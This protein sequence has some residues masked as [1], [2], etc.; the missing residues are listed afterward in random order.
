MSINEENLRRKIPVCPICGG[1]YQ[2]KKPLFQWTHIEC[3]NCKAQFYSWDLTSESGIIED[4]TLIKMPKL[5]IIKEKYYKFE[6]LLNISKD[7]EYWKTID[8]DQAFV[9]SSQINDIINKI[10]SI[11]FLN[12]PI[13]FYLENNEE[14][15]DITDVFYI[16]NKI[17][18]ESAS[19]GLYGHGLMGSVS[20]GSFSEKPDKG[21]FCTCYL[22]NR[23]LVFFE[24]KTK[25]AFLG[26]VSQT[27]ELFSIIYLDNIE[28]INKHDFFKAKYIDLSIKNETKGIIKISYYCDIHKNDVDRDEY[29]KM[30][31]NTRELYIK[32]KNVINDKNIPIDVLNM[33]LAK[34]EISIEEYEK[35][36]KVLS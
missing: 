15:V 4:L 33:R 8:I 28:S 21:R 9:K 20:S 13:P 27:K 26:S 31:T 17:V 35:L 32:N 14:L 30:L 25:I 18:M 24:H 29:I 19:F 2:W 36:K 23:R 22:T 6:P 10:D 12:I 16:G 7:I 1:T 34:G 5:E 11:K 3:N